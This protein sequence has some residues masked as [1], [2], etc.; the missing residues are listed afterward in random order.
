MGGS[1][2]CVFGEFFLFKAIES[3]IVGAVV[4]LVASNFVLVTIISSLGEGTTLT[5]L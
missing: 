5:A 2:L 1:V 4:A 3:G